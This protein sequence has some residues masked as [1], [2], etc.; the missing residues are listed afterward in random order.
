[1]TTTSDV[2]LSHKSD[3]KP[4]VDVLA[5][6]LRNRGYR[7]FFDEWDMIPGQ[8]IVQQLYDGLQQSRKGILVVTPEAIDSGWVR[9]DYAQMMV[10]KQQDAAFTI[11]PVIVGEE[12]PDFPFIQDILWVDF[13]DPERYR[14]AFYR[15]VCALDGTSP[16]P[17]VRLDGELVVPV[18]HG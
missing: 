8:S 6:N 9:E 13:R 3:W 10:Q 12:V 5:R 17:D 11:I 1:M 18:R 16:G 14:E 2:F 4:W 15:L 7:V